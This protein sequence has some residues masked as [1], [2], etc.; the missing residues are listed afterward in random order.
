VIRLPK[1]SLKLKDYDDILD[2]I[3]QGR[4]LSDICHAKQITPY[5]W[6]TTIRKDTL[7]SEKVKAAQEFYI[8]SQ[9]DSLISLADAAE[10]QV[11]VQKA[12]IKS[13]NIKWL[14]S[15]RSRETYGDRTDINI[16]QT[17]DLSS[18]LNAANSRVLPMLR[19]VQ[20]I[21]DASDATEAIEVIE[22]TEFIEDIL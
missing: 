20:K 4:A 16:H 21:S 11:D 14:A 19:E 13:E 22:A 9:V 15:K 10:T 3:S 1:I 17:L 7:F 2:M 6:Q 8:E 18:V 12:K 5:F